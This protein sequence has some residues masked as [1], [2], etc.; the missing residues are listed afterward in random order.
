[1]Q[2][3]RRTF[4]RL[5]AAAA[6][7]ALSRIALAD[8]YPSRPVHIVV[9]L[10]PGSASDII[11]R[12]AGNWMSERLSQPFVVENKSGAAGVLAAETVVR[13]AP[14]GYTLLLYSSADASNAAL[15]Y[16]LSF[17]VIHDIAPVASV[18]QG[19]LILVVNPSFA[20][21]TVP[22]FIAYAKA[23]PGKVNFGSAGTGTVAHLAGE[24]FKSVAGVELIHVPYRGLAPALGDLIGGRLQAVFST[25]PPAIKLVKAGK[26]RALA[27][28]SPT[29]FSTLPDLPSMSDLLPG[30][31]VNIS[32]GLGAPQ[33]TPSD[34]I[35]KLNKETNAGLADA[36]IR[37]RLL[38]LGM[39]AMP[40]SPS[41]FEKLRVAETKKWAAVIKQA[42]LM[43]KG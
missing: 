27:V 6:L 16:D 37:A 14:D 30:Y 42:H 22:E 9:G 15:H 11:A 18:A 29:R 12:L 21:T 23:N 3:P 38:D 25:M 24:L 36:G 2:L 13:S 10:A 7:P 34:I 33:N 41:D 39:T 26:L 35:Q 17:N 40:L 1:M 8:T 43:P 32:V 5:A 20:A 28:T 31:E 19:P 4:L